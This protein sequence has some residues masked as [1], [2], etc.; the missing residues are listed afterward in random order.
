M[1]VKS[2]VLYADIHYLNFKYSINKDRMVYFYLKI[3]KFEIAYSVH[4]R[5]WVHEYK[6]MYVINC[7]DSPLIDARAQITLFSS[8]AVAYRSVL[9]MFNFLENV[10]IS[11]LIVKELPV[12]EK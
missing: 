7:S 2:I 10:I 9:F 4:E 11:R 6:A 1:E 5:A 12:N 8:M 3:F